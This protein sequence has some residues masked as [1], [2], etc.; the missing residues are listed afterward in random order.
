M[1]KIK[2]KRLIGHI[3]S[4]AAN[5]TILKLYQLIS[6]FVWREQLQQ[7]CLCQFMH[8]KQI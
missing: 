6:E 5:L 4:S 3:D 7:P 2:I 1:N 8:R